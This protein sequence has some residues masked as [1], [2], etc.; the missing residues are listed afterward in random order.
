VGDNFNLNRN[1]LPVKYKYYRDRWDEKPAKFEAMM[2]VSALIPVFEKN[3]LFIL[4]V[5]GMKQTQF[6]RWMRHSK[7]AAF[8]Y[9]FRERD[10]NRYPII[11]LADWKAICN[12]LKVD[13][14]DMMFSEL[15]EKWPK[16]AEITNRAEVKKKSLQ[17]TGS[18]TYKNTLS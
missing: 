4:Q 6:R 2:Q 10:H 17:A 14:R 16:T 7:I 18:S 5:R 11:D 9:L 8:R 3:I 1:P 13:L 15:A 12:H